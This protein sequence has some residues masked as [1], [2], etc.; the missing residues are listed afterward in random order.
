MLYLHNHNIK[1]MLLSPSNGS[2]RISLTCLV[3]LRLELEF[4]GNGS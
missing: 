4:P 3:R 1:T 2:C